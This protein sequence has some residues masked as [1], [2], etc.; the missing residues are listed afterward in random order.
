MSLRDSYLAWLTYAVLP[1]TAKW[2]GRR[3]APVGSAV[4]RAARGAYPTFRGPSRFVPASPRDAGVLYLADSAETALIEA[5]ARGRVFVTP[6]TSRDEHSHA[7][8]WLTF[9]S[10]TQPDMAEFD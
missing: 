8:G 2:S 3:E 10:R 4:R 9:G 6:L 1:Q 7:F 5:F